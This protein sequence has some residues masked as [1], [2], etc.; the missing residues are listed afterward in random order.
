MKS[1][2]QAV[3]A[4]IELTVSIVTNPRSTGA[5]AKF[6]LLIQPRPYSRTE[7]TLFGRV[8]E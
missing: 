4:D 3:R 6:S 5:V 8:I 2:G 1:I 7:E